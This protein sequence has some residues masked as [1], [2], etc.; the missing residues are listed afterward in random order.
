M[1]NL[2]YITLLFTVILYAC[3]PQKKSPEMLDIQ[4][5]EKNFSITYNRMPRMTSIKPHF[6]GTAL[7]IDEVFAEGN[8]NTLVFHYGVA[9][10]K[11]VKIHVDIYQEKNVIILSISPDGLQP[12]DGSQYI[13]I[14]ID[15]LPLYLRGVAYYKYP[16]VKAWT[17]PYLVPTPDSLKYTDN[18]FYYWQYAD[19]LTACAMPLMGK[20]YVA[21][22]GNTDGK[23]CIKAR[24]LASNFN[25]EKIPIAAIGFG[26]DFYKNVSNVYNIGLKKI[27]RPAALRSEKSYPEVFEHLAWCTWNSFMH[28]LNQEKLIEGLESF[29]KNS[30][31]LPSVLLDDGWMQATAYGTGKLKALETNPEKFPQGLKYAIDKVKNDYGVKNVGIWHAYSGYWAGVDT[32]T[33]LYQKNKSWFVPY[34]DKVAWAQGGTSTFYGPSPL[35]ITDDN[36]YNAWYKYFKNEGIDFVKVDNQLV[37]DRI[38]QGNIAFETG[39]ANLQTNMQNAV[40]KYFDGQVINCMDMTTDAVYNFGTSAIGRSSEDY[41][42]ENNTYK[43]TSGNEAV[44]ITCNAYNSIWWSQMVWSDWDMFQSHHPNATYHAVARAISGGPIYITDIPGKQNFEIINRLIDDDGKILRANLPAL[45]T[46]DCLYDVMQNKPLKIFSMSGNVGLLGVFHN[47]DNEESSTSVSPAD[48]YDMQVSDY[49]CYD[50]FNNTYKIMKYDETYQVKLRRLTVQLYYFIPL[51]GNLLPIGILE[52]YNAPKTY[53]AYISDAN[54]YNIVI[55]TSGTFA[56]G[57]QKGT[58]K[59]KIQDQDVP[60]MVLKNNI[61]TFAVSKEN[62]G[63][64]YVITIQ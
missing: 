37:N 2:F 11:H 23:L 48:V 42:P 6:E 50:Y 53:N 17:H 14:V 58:P 10:E 19:S 45:P 5:D 49:M 32:N 26:K 29:K 20:G 44:H 56:F 63:M 59:V 51:K 15:S 22:L 47:M 34:T 27:N 18:Q 31:T 12:Q 4:L 61:Y 16:Q 54:N 52:K 28:S 3:T 38:C 30:F 39:A 41:F 7:N 55:N 21:T 36:I 62:V 8:Q 13:G 60:M 24:C 35:T 64:D 33:T 43:M 25:A 40:K 9:D 1:K 46:V 57:V